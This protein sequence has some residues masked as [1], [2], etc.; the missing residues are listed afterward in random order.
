[1]DNWHDIYLIVNSKHE[2]LLKEA[3]QSRLLRDGST[4]HA[5]WVIA[6]VLLGMIVGWVR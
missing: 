1:M 3:K 4:P 6:I 5:L 2:E